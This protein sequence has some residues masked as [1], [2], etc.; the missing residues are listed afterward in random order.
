MT[1]DA[2]LQ[3]K[4]IDA[5]AAAFPD[6]QAI[7]LFGSFGTEDEWPSSDADIAILLP[8]KQTKEVRSFAMH[9]LTTELSP[10]VHRDVDLINLRYVSTVFRKEIVMA[11]RR[12]YTADVFAAD[13]FD[14]LTLSFYQRLNEERSDIFRAGLASG[15]FIA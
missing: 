12:I 10:I 14:M 13:E 11:D 5:I 4:I 7:Y 8:P 15:R 1:L 9:P 6:V 2:D 3:Q